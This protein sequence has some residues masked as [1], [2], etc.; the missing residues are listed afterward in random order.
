MKTKIALAVSLALTSQSTLSSTLG[1][2]KAPDKIGMEVVVK[3]KID[4]ALTSQ[5]SLSAAEIKQ[6]PTGNGNLTDLL[7]SNPAIRFS[8][9]GNNSMN[10]GE[11]KPEDISIH[12]S[13]AYQNTF[14]LDG[15]TINNDLDP[16]NNKLGVTNSNLSSDEQGFYLDSRLI[17]SIT[18]Y[19]AN[20]PAEFGGFTGG[21]I[22]VNSRSWQGENHASV[23]YRMTD[24]SWNK[25]HVDEQLNFSSGNNDASN[26][27]RFQPKYS[28]KSFGAWFEAGI[29]DDLGLVF[30]LSR[31]NSSIPMTN[32]G[33]KAVTLDKE[34]K[35]IG[36]TTESNI[37]EQTRVSDNLFTKLTWYAT[38]RTTAN[39]S[40]T[41]SGYDSEMFM[42][43]TA[44]SD[45]SES[46]NGLAS[47]LNIEHAFDFGMLDMGISIQNMQD[48]RDSEQNYYVSLKDYT[49]WQNPT[50]FSSG[51]PG[52][53]TTEQQNVTANA[54]MTLDPLQFGNSQHTFT[55]GTEITQTN[56]KFIRDE[57]YYRNSYQG[58]WDSMEWLSSA[59]QVDAFF[60]GTYRTD[61]RNYSLF[62]DDTIS[63]GNVNIRPGLRIDRDSFVKNTNIAPRLSTS[64]N[65]FGDGS[66]MLTAGLNRYY[67]RSML[68]YALYEGQNGG[69][70][71]CYMMCEPNSEASSNDWV[72]TNDFEGMSD[73]DTPYNDE[74]A[75]SLQQR[76]NNSMIKLA[77]VHRNGYD[78]VRSRPKYPGTKNPGQARIRT[79]DNNGKTQHDN[80]I[81]S[82]RNTQPLRW[83]ATDNNLTASVSWQQTSSNTPMDQGYA[84]YDPSINLDQD[85]VWYDGKIIA[86]EDLP[87]TDFNAPLLVN[88]EWTTKINQY[89]LTW[90]NLANWQS[91]REQATRHEN[92]YAIDPST[93]KQVLKYE[94]V[95]FASTF[96]WN[97][98]LMWQPKF[99]KGA[100][101]SIEVNNVLNNKNATDSFV[102]NDKVYRTYEAGR[103]F[104][105]QASYDI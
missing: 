52:D 21:V 103:Q 44:N 86:A 104:W 27:S 30:S 94:S 102:Y 53:L 41:Y 90:Y 14:N 46:H 82:A 70:K 49:D 64:W 77:Y 83:L 51:G 23:F 81:L 37:K 3:D 28:K 4:P 29:T 71:H 16:A 38:P 48:I 15:M 96:R 1:A 79:F 7:K 72:E 99:A 32:V 101:L 91:S 61:Y 93:N 9:S 98:K 80:V 8:N 60:A 74:L 33:K 69:L 55:F 35:V 54:K 5:Q 12:G 24:S 84:F 95:K 62:F 89:G 78:E 66:T 2:E 26:P 68:T 65:V 67:G 88:L 47:S 105:L 25:N 19:D 56:A 87:S 10:Q 50:E 17:D 59:S 43:G 34:N 6:R 58:M 40:M 97:T 85:K 57:T 63:I 39:W 36:F 73:L 75:M 13:T 100:A 11:I 76:W 92:A 18:V 31:R 20:I 42:N 45:Y 22:D